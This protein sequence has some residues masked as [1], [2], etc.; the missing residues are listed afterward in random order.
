MGAAVQARGCQEDLGLPQG[1]EAPGPREQAVLRPRCQDAA[2]LRQGQ[3]PRLRN[4]QVP[5]D[6]SD[7]PLDDQRPNTVLYRAVLVRSVLY[8]TL[9]CTVLYCTLYCTVLY[10]SVQCCTVLKKTFKYHLQ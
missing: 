4:G 5:Q 2:H 1:A 6:P 10:L 7:Q 9:D 3:G 8:C